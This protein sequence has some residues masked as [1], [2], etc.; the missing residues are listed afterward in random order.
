MK[1]NEI[2]AKTVEKSPYTTFWGLLKLTDNYNEAYK[3]DIK[4][5]W[6]LK[7]SGNKTSSLKELYNTNRYMY[8]FNDWKHEKGGKDNGRT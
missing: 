5:A 4:K 1:A 8:F 2:N 7:Y 6:V 3:E